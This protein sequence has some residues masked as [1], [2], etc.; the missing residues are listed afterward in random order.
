MIGALFMSLAVGCV[1][2][3]ALRLSMSN[4]SRATFGPRIRIRTAVTGWG[5]ALL[6]I[7]SALPWTFMSSSPL[8]GVITWLFCILPLAALPLIIIWP[9]RPR[10]ALAV[11]ALIFLVAAAVLG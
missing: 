6:L 2:F 3:S 7:L 4:A 10:A 8:I 5:G 1:G 11:P 9:F